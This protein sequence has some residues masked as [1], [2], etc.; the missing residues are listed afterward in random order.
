[1]A[2]SVHLELLWHQPSN[3]ELTSYSIE[4]GGHMKALAGDKR[5]IPKHMLIETHSNLSDTESQPYKTM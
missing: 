3:V 2:L 4:G 1:M 5:S